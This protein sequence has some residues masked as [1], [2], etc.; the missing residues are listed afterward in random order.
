MP[1]AITP[2]TRRLLIVTSFVLLGVY[3]ALTLAT[4]GPLASLGIEAL[5]VVVG[6]TVLVA[7]SLNDLGVATGLLSTGYLVDAGLAAFVVGLATVP[8]SR[9]AA[10]HRELERRTQEL[11]TRSRELRRSY[12]DLR[13]TQEELVKKEQLAVVGE[14]A[15]VIAHEVRNPLAIIGNAVAGLRKP[16][17]SREDHDTLLSILDEETT[18]FAIGDVAQYPRQV[19]GA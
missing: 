4:R 10:V 6:S 16:V 13:V 15:A 7:T 14:L 3:A 17:I 19:I 5:A 18:L 11:R 8:S 12:E 2:R 1:H 9:Y